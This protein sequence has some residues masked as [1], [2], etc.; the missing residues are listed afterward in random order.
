MAHQEPSNPHRPEDYLDRAPELGWTPAIVAVAFLV[1]FG[2]LIFGG[3][4]S[5]DQPASTARRSELPNPAPSAPS[6][7]TPSPPK[8]Q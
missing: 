7:P 2:F 5:A 4:R 3:P 6:I 8:P 1:V